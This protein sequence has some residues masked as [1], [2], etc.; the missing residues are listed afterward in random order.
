ML[1][2]LVGTG[3][4][5]KSGRPQF[6][7]PAVFESFRR[8]AEQDV[9]FLSGTEARRAFADLGADVSRARLQEWADDDGNISFERFHL[10][11]SRLKEVRFWTTI[12]PTGDVIRKRRRYWKRFLTAGLKTGTRAAHLGSGV[13]SLGIGAID[14]VDFVL[15]CGYQHLSYDEA[16][17]HSLVHLAAAI[18]SLPRFTYKWDPLHP[19][20]LGLQSARDANMWSSA[21]IYLW[22]CLLI[23]SDVTLPLSE[24]RV[25]MTSPGFQVSTLSASALIVY[26]AARTYWE[27]SDSNSGVYDDVRKN[28]LLVVATMTLPL[29]ADT[30]RCLLLAS[31][32]DSV[33]SFRAL[34][35]AYP[36]YTHIFMG[37]CLATL[38][39]GNVVCALSSAEHH[40]AITKQE[41][42]SI[43]NGLVS[44]AAATAVLG[45]LSVDDGRLASQMLTIVASSIF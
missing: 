45:V 5:V 23:A 32:A 8:H 31:S 28:T 43:N 30:L 29:L 1:L 37:S 22:Y 24:A 21:V 35:D 6:V 34:V 17:C 16:L 27:A 13:L 33:A 42:A 15:S 38:F 19:W 40:S 18:F 10:H 2:S 44:I 4:L 25:F 7:H 12:D 39:S 11:S 14:F 20:H 36:E 9:N 26:G 41:I 3:I